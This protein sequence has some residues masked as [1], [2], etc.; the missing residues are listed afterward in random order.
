MYLYV[1]DFKTI[2]NRDA[3]NCQPVGRVF[4]SEISKIYNLSL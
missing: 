1:R 4:Q 2:L 3:E